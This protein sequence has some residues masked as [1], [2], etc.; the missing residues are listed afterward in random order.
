MTF[1]VLLLLFLFLLFMPGTKMP[2]EEGIMVSFGDAKFP[3][4]AGVLD[5]GERR[6]AR[7]TA[8]ARDQDVIGIALRDTRGK[9]IDGACGQLVATEEDREVAAS[10][11]IEA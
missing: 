10:V 2:E 1:M 7:T 8:I 3:R 11:A 6:G 4:Q 9:E 5:A